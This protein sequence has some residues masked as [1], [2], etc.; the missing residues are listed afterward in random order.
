V[1]SN[2]TKIY[3]TIRPLPRGKSSIA[4]AR[5]QFFVDGVALEMRDA[6]EWQRNDSRNCPSI[7]RH[8]Q[9]LGR[10]FGN[11]WLFAEWDDQ[12][13]DFEVTPRSLTV[14]ATG[15]NKTYDGRQT[16]P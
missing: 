5:L 8:T 13:G 7:C 4:S 1:S 11:R 16:R 10:V 12:C 2:D 14:S 6:F 9:H 15:V 3:V